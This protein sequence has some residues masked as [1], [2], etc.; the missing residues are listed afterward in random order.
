MNEDETLF[1]TMATFCC[2]GCRM[3]EWVWFNV[4][5]ESWEVI[6][7]TMCFQSEV[8]ENFQ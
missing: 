3:S 5:P 4:Q 8:P 2:T 7:G 1:H 6:L